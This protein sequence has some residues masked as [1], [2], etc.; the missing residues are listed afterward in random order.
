MDRK[1]GDRPRQGGDRKR[2]GAEKSFPP[3]RSFD[4]PRKD[5]GRSTGN[6]PGRF[7]T[8]QRD[9]GIRAELPQMGDALRDLDTLRRFLPLLDDRHEGS[10]KLL[11]GEYDYGEFILIVE[12]IPDEPSRQPARLRARMRRETARFPYDV[13][14]TRS[15]ETG[16][17]DFLARA[18]SDAAGRAPSER[19]GV[20]AGRIAIDRPGRELLESSAVVVS[21]EIIEVRFTVEL[22][23]RRGRIPSDMVSELFLATIP[24]VIRSSLIFKNVDGERLADFIET[25]ERAD[26]IRAQLEERGLVAFIADGSLLP[27]KWREGETLTPF[28]APE[29]LAVTFDL[30][31]GRTVRGMGI[32]KGI[33]LVAGGTGSGKSTL[34]RAIELGVYNHIPGDGRELAVTI[35]DA[36]GVRTE[37]GRRIEN[38]DVS[39][40]FDPAGGV[41]TRRY[42]AR[43]A[44]SSFS[45]AANVMEALEIGASILVI[46]DDMTPAG[47]VTRDARIQALV[48][49]DSEPA[50]TL[51]DLLPAFRDDLGVSS[52]IA[53]NSGD[54]FDIADTVILMEGFLPGD[55]TTR[56]KVISGEPKSKRTPKRLK[57]SAPTPRTPL[58]NSLEPEK[59]TAGESLRPQGKG[60]IQYGDEFIDCSRLP[61]LASGSQERAIARGI[62]L[63]YRLMDSSASLEE[64]VGKV[65]ERV[66]TVGLDTLSGRLMGDLAMFRAHELAAAVNRMK[67]LKV[68]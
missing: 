7:R 8:P 13:F 29:E 57:I 59:N 45:Y 31:N 1:G 68:K 20:R 15:R 44:S 53:V 32:P 60:F 66:R 33:T 21:N 24:A 6:S 42:C 67:N 16:A 56:A 28:H 26:M 38:V 43:W 18:F 3:R 22:P 25:N 58:A 4:R 50:A 37:E 23:V 39:P 40:F 12:H 64:A 30:P 9:T 55:A 54:F 48:P 61:Q 63:V 34:L 2:Q 49:S 62:A 14:N 10:Y 27:G 46:D 65:M 5:Q 36:V 19:R 17:R 52:V 41:D 11:A 47:L 35:A 51:I